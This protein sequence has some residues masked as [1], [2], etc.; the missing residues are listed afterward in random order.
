VH[1]LQLIIGLQLMLVFSVKPLSQTK[2][3]YFIS[4]KFIFVLYLFYYE[5]L[6]P[7]QNK[8]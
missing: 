4:V 2:V 8:N 7:P 6:F 3:F 1:I 5:S